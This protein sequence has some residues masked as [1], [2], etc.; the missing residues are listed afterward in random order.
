[1]DLQFST[2]CLPHYPLG[3]SFATARALGLD[4]LELALTPTILR[5]GPGRV[6]DLAERHAVAVRSVL[7]PPGG[8]D[9]PGRDEVRE[10][11]GFAAALPGCRVLVL[12]APHSDGGAAPLGAFV[13][14]LQTM[15]DTLAA[16]GPALTIEN[17]PPPAA[18]N[19]AG[20]L[21][22]FSQ[23]RRLVEEWDLGFTFD[24]SHAAG[25]GWVI[26]EPLSRMGA[27]LRNVHL[28]DFRPG[29]GGRLELLPDRTR[30]QHAHGLPGTGVLPLHAFLRA[31]ARQGYAGLLTL[32]LH[33]GSV[34]AWWPPIA[35]RRLAGALAFCRAATREDGTPRAD[36]LR[37]AVETPAEA[38]AENEG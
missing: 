13:S 30:P 10:I 28:S 15:T 24:T 6:T 34:G 17:P 5:G 21:D 16:G 37:R 19:V 11:V 22:R 3:Y 20:P 36:I 7:L 38:E 25:H 9:A 31:L 32:D 1:M 2:A 14:F 23:L 8:R 33:G 4:S 26:T 27:R 18:G 29:P 35:R 12:P